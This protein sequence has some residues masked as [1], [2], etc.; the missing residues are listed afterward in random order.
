MLHAIYAA[1]DISKKRREYITLE[2][3][4][5]KHQKIDIENLKKEKN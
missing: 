1:T 3:N 4:A 2:S 5:L